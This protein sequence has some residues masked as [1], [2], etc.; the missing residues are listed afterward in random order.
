MCASLQGNGPIIILGDNGHEKGPKTLAI[1][2]A[3]GVARLSGLRGDSCKA[4]EQILET[5]SI[6][7]IVSWPL[8][9][10]VG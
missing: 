7:S 3:R 1:S 8:W 10:Q 6:V 2:M 4:Q 5:E 9:H